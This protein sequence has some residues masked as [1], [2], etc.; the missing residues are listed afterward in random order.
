[1]GHGVL[2]IPTTQ[3]EYDVIS[4]LVD[5][6]GISC[7]HINGELTT[8]SDRTHV[9]HPSISSLWFSADLCT[10]PMHCYPNATQHRC[11]F[12]N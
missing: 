7:N 5:R 8:S 4:L 1:M 12:L 9:D 10:Q 6:F 11:K 2:Y 3:R